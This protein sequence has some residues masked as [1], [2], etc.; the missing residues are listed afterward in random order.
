[1][2]SLSSIGAAGLG[3]QFKG[4]R[5][6]RKEI[7]LFLLGHGTMKL[8]DE[9][10][11]YL[12]LR[13]EHYGLLQAYLW[14]KTNNTA[15]KHPYHNNYHA[16]CVMLN[17]IDAAETEMLSFSEVQELL[18][19][20]LFH[21]ANHSGGML[22]DSE[23]I[24]AA[25]ARL[26]EAVSSGVVPKPLQAPASRLIDATQHPYVRAAVSAAERILRDA[27][28]MNLFGSYWFEHVYVGLR[29]EL[30]HKLGPLTLA[31]FC[32]MQEPFIETLKFGSI[33]GQAQGEKYLKEA[34]KKLATARYV[35][36]MA[37]AHQLDDV[38]MFKALATAP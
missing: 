26:N 34:K 32:E 38:T 11:L 21:D 4:R 37:K 13:L 15:N 7:D 35:C 14:F 5:Y 9:K 22:P 23:N 29:R 2:N 8:S 27:D 17:C 3:H 12:Q 1:M 6:T 30:Q 33:W 25:L 28:L 18:L 19:A 20:A 31:A 24:K 10:R 16:E 36:L